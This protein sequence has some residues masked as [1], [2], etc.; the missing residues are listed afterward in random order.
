MLAWVTMFPGFAV[1]HPRLHNE[2]GFM[3][4]ITRKPAFWIA[5]A[6]LSA[7]SALLAWRY[8]PEALPLIN[9]DVKM[10][11]EQALEEAAAIGDR[12]HLVASGAHRAASFTHDGSTQNYVE[13]EG[14]G[15]PAFT[16]LLSGEIYSPY[17]WEVRLF[18][19]GET[20]EARVRFKPDSSVY[21][22]VRNV[23]E[24]ERGASLDTAVA[25]TIAEARARSDWGV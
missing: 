1:A 21:G 9:L 24:D 7:I 16:Q 25:C 18:K 6:L 11:R 14:G 8:F 13:L 10:S 12:L 5:F 22:F 15:K 17:R 4:G 20:A 2:K 19:P 3:T 23:P